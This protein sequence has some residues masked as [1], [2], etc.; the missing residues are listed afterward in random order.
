MSTNSS[1]TSVLKEFSYDTV[2]KSNYHDPEKAISMML[3]SVSLYAPKRNVH[4]IARS[5]LKS[6]IAIIKR[7]RTEKI[8]VW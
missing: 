2:L 8:N 7:L 4:H 5:R 6:A 3:R 1:T